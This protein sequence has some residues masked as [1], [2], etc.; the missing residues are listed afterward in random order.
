MLLSYIISLL[1]AAP[2]VWASYL[3]QDNRMVASIILG[4]ALVVFPIFGFYVSERIL[5]KR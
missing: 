3:L 4:G 2:F 1:C 5:R